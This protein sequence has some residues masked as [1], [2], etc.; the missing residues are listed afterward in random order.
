MTVKLKAIIAE[1]EKLPQSIQDT[2]AETIATLIDEI[3]WEQR[4]A[5]PKKQQMMHR[6]ALE[7]LNEYTNDQTEEWP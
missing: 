7:A 5:D 2:L 3:G 6:M 1:A 4:F